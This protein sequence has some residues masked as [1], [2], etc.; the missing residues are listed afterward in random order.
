MFDP[1]LSAFGSDL[2][3]GS[4]SATVVAGNGVGNFIG[5]DV[6]AVATQHVGSEGFGDFFG[7]HNLG[8]NDATVVAGNGVGNFIG[9]DV[10]AIATQD[11]GDHGFPHLPVFPL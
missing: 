4:N 8:S 3:T 1:W 5:G 11:I 7:S 2:N 6:N 9:G 10:N